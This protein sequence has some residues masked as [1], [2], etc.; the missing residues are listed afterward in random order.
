MPRRVTL[1]ARGVPGH[2][3]KP[4]LQNAVVILAAAVAKAGAW[5]TEVRLNETTRTYF[6]RM[7]EI[8]EPDDAFRY[9]NVE[10][11][12]ESDAIQQH[13]I[14]SFP[15]HYSISRTSVAPTV[16]DGG[17]RK[18]VIPSEASAILDIR[19]LPD[20]DVADF[21]AKL[22][23][24]IDDPRIEIVPERIYRPAAP[25]SDIDNEMFQTLERVAKQM[26]P[27]A[28]VLPIMATGATDMAQVRAVGMQA[29]GIGPARTVEEI[30]SGFGAHGDNERISEDAF[31]DLVKYM[32]NVVIEISTTQ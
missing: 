2:G 7:A 8:S 6:Q 25:P 1:I 22:T 5:Q 31:V 16:F 13:F 18:N 29:Y 30:N 4:T 12:E 32:W 11:A 23:A 26:Y 17:F 27:D 19:M 24:I 15:Y 3:S 10:N 14:E 28:T 9:N 20:E 21:Y